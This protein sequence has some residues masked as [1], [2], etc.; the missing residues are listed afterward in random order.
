MRDGPTDSPSEM[1]HGGM[2]NG[3]Q[4]GPVAYLM[5]AIHLKLSAL[6][7]ESRLTSMTEMLAFTRK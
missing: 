1:K 3:Q 7:E 6:E 4:I 2:V 5:R